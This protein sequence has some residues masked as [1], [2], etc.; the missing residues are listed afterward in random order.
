[1]KIKQH[2]HSNYLVSFFSIHS[3][4]GIIWLGW[5]MYD[6]LKY[7]RMMREYYDN[8]AT[9]SS[10]FKLVEG[11]DG[12]LIISMPLVTSKS[13]T[14]RLPEYYC[15]TSGRHSGSLFM[16]I[17]AAFFCLLSMVHLLL[18]F[19]KQLVY[20]NTVDDKIDNNGN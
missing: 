17:G 13:N 3:L 1:M 2:I 12:E 20:Y 11:E 8:N 9:E 16:R 18:L 14:E 7:I 19:S 15:F 10:Q 6:I 5:L 4:V